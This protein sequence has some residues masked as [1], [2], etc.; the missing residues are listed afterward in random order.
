MNPNV[1]ITQDVKVVPRKP[2]TSGK[3]NIIGLTRS[4]L[5]EAMLAVGTPARQAKM[6]LGQLWQWVY[7][8]GLRDFSQMTNLSKDYRLFLEEYFT[9]DLP[10]VVTRQISSDGTR[11]YLVRIQGGHEVETVYIPENGRGTLCIS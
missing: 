7:H 10:E 1:P 5:L 9:I 6:R 11:K 8:W 2:D 3:V 4:Q